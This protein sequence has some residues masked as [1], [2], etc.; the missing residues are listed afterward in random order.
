VS[1]PFYERTKKE[2]ADVE[3]PAIEYAQKRGWWHMKVNSTTRNAMPDD[4]FVRRGVYVWWEFKAPGEEPSKQQL[5]RHRDMRA[6]G[7]DVRW[8]DSLDAFTEQMK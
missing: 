8:T 3:D 5:K 1:R 7:M 2:R 4:L 6:E